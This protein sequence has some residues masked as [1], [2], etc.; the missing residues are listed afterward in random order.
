MGCSGKRV[1]IVIMR[2]QRSGMS[3][4]KANYC[5]LNLRNFTFGNSA[6]SSI[7]L[8]QSATSQLI[9]LHMGIEFLSSSPNLTSRGSESHRMLKVPVYD[10]VN[11]NREFLQFWDIF[12]Q[13]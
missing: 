5:L 9:C 2:C 13:S 10:G 3:F 8:H 4:G 12:Q 1:L 7:S 6:A 11:G